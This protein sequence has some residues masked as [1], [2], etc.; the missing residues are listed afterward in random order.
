M[1]PKTPA[2]QLRES[3]DDVRR[4]AKAVQRRMR[5][6]VQLA[7]RVEEDAAALADSIEPVAQRRV[8]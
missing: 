6:L 7:A 5:V 4:E 3:A 8:E 2:E 1:E